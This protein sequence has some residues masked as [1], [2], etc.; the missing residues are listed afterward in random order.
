MLRWRTTFTLKVL[1]WP[2]GVR[3][4]VMRTGSI[5]GWRSSQPAMQVLTSALMMPTVFIGEPILKLML[6]RG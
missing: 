4:T 2:P 5:S 3:L 1:A 6:T